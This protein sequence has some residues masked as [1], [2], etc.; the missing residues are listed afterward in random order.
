VLEERDQIARR[1]EAQ[2]FDDRVL[3]RKYEFESRALIV[4]REEGGGAIDPDRRIVDVRPDARRYRHAIDQRTADEL[5]VIVHDHV[6]H[7]LVERWAANGSE[8]SV[9][10]ALSKICSTIIFWTMATRRDSS[11]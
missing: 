2:A 11:R 7:A 5:R 8:I 6:R 4:G 1:G 9:P 10:V 3:C